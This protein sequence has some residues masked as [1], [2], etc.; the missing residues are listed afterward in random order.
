MLFGQV[1]FNGPSRFVDE[2]P[3]S[4]YQWTKLKGNI[5]EDDEF[6]FGSNRMMQRPRF[7]KPKNAYDEGIYQSYDDEEVVYQIKESVVKPKFPKGS[8]IR[9]ALYGDG[10]VEDSE[11]S[12]NDEKV[13][14]K[15]LDGNR[16]KF[17]VKF[18][19]LSLL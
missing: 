9:H 15:F 3:E 6:N 8:K 14:I 5:D 17:M 19:P 16:K 4:L 2:I 13:T 10:K 12:G 1:K 11:G 18:A 7:E